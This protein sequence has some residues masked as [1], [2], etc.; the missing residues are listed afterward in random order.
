MWN[1]MSD[2]FKSYINPVALP[3]SEYISKLVSEQIHRENDRQPWTIEKLSAHV[4]IEK[5]FNTIIFLFFFS[6]TRFISLLCIVMTSYRHFS[7]KLNYKEETQLMEE[8]KVC[9]K[10]RVYN[11]KHV[12][13]KH[14]DI[15]TWRLNQPRGR[16]SKNETT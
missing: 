10:D 14:M 3:F 2:F 16:L 5:N 12:L 11:V 9:I 7:N 8:R 1:M 13:H 6:P 4:C 15:A